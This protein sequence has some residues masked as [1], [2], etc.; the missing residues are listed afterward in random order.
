M[1]VALRYVA[2]PHKNGVVADDIGGRTADGERRG[3]RRCLRFGTSGNGEEPSEGTESRNHGHSRTHESSGRSSRSFGLQ[4]LCPARPAGP[5]NRI[6]TLYEGLACPPRYSTSPGQFGTTGS[7][8][9]SVTSPTVDHRH[10]RRAR[11]ARCLKRFAS[12]SVTPNDAPA[13]PL[14]CANSMTIPSLGRQ[15]FLPF[16]PP[17]IGE[18]EIAEV[19]DTLRSGWITTG[20]KTKRFESEFTAYLGAPGSLA[21]NSCTAALHTALVTLGIKHGDEVIT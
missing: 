5:P 19:V 9:K 4:V 15:T 13:R 6:G 20:P 11:A 1:P 2:C 10:R 21:L 7:C 3:K 18:E 8:S 14:R 17:L 12:S 16:A